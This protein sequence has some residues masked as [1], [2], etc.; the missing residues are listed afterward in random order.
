MSCFLTHL[1]VITLRSKRDALYTIQ[2]AH[3]KAMKA[4]NIFTH[5]SDYGL[6]SP[7]KSRT[8]HWISLHWALLDC[9]IELP[10][11]YSNVITKPNTLNP[12]LSL[13]PRVNELFMV[14]KTCKKRK[15]DFGS[16]WS[17]ATIPK[18]AFDILLSYWLM[19]HLGH[20]SSSLHGRHRLP[21]TCSPPDPYQ[22]TNYLLW[23]S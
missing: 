11:T 4:E 15:D 5:I 9:K 1:L 8:A 18:G 19:K 12:S 22:N 17:V 13:T 3:N 14:I 20:L 21:R 6:F 2:G 23:T 16:R 7:S 10:S